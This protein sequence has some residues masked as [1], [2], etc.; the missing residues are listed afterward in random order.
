MYYIDVNGDYA[1]QHGKI[2]WFDGKPFVTCRFT[3][4]NGSQYEGISRNAAQLA[5]TL[6][7]Q[8]TTP[9]SPGGYS[10]VC[11]RVSYGLA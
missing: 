3:L 7:A 10:L 4:W 1:G 8:P 9:D 6:N 2:L 11:S 5:A